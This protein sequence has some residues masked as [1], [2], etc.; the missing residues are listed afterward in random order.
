MVQRKVKKL[1]NV[2]TKVRERSGCKYMVWEEEKKEKGHEG[3]AW[4]RDS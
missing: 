4:G 1:G 3:W 2:M